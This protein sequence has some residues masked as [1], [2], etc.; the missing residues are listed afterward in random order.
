MGQS[1][2][3]LLLI[4]PPGR[5]LCPVGGRGKALDGGGKNQGLP[6]GASSW[7]LHVMQRFLTYSRCSS[8]QVAAPLA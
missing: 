8:I 1:N 5:I 2:L 7:G 3:S 6:G 4:D